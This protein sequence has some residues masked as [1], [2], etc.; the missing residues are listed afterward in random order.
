MVDSRKNQA[1]GPRVVSAGRAVG[2]VALVGTFA[3]AAARYFGGD[4]G[5]SHQRSGPCGWPAYDPAGYLGQQ[6]KPTRGGR[7]DFIP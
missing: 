4:V 3:H 6:A 7:T 5:M 1:S 2:T